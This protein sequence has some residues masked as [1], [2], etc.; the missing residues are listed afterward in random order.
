MGSVVTI[1]YRNLISEYFLIFK[2]K[3]T[4]KTC[5]T[6]KAITNR[7]NVDFSHTSYI[8]TKSASLHQKNS[9]ASIFDSYH[10][11]FD[12]V[13]ATYLLEPWE[14]RIVKGTLLILTFIMLFSSIYFLSSYSS[15][16]LQY[17]GF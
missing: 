1:Q 15:A 16:F 4:S 12:Y 8:M 17:L 5:T 9:L 6:R 14:R 13:T 11:E 3:K 7:A 2:K 10:R